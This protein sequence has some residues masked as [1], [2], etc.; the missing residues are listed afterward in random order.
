MIDAAL[1]AG[2]AR[3]RRGELPGPP[4]ANGLGSFTTTA[5]LTFRIRAC[6]ILSLRQPPPDEPSSANRQGADCGPLRST[7]S[8]RTSGGSVIHQLPRIRRITRA[9]IE[10]TVVSSATQR[11]GLTVCTGCRTGNARSCRGV[12]VCLGGQD[13]RSRRRRRPGGTS[14][15]TFRMPSRS[16]VHISAS[17]L[18]RQ[19]PG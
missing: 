13:G 15:R 17:P 9:V 2:S 14:T 3:L 5:G 12:V 7:S 1:A 8:A 10:S 18:A 19:V 16:S 4:S 11:H 6:P